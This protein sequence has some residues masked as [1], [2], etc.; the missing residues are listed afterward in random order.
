MRSHFYQVGS[1]IQYIC[2]LQASF[3]QTALLSVRHTERTDR[4]SGGQSDCQHIASHPLFIHPFKWRAAKVWRNAGSHQKQTNSHILF[5]VRATSQ[6]LASAKNFALFFL[7]PPNHAI[8]F[9]IG[10][11]R[12]GSFAR[13]PF[14]HTYVRAP[15]VCGKTIGRNS[16]ERRSK[17]QNAARGLIVSRCFS[18]CWSRF[19]LCATA[20][21]ANCMLCMTVRCE[22]ESSFCPLAKQSDEYY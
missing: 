17:G 2:S 12:G 15:G 20:A 8:R 19:V 3:R 1:R 10:A 21:K 18:A 9:M 4:E 22:I 5:C 6:L 14:G 7:S 13:R 16:R 11:M